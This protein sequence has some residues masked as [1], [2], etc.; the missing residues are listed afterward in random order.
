M[1]GKILLIL[2]IAIIII[3]TLT[4]ITYATSFIA[5]NLISPI[6]SVPFLWARLLIDVFVYIISLTIVFLAGA[7]IGKFIERRVPVGLDHLRASMIS[8]AIGIISG[9]IVIFLL[10]VHIFGLMVTST[11]FMAVLIFVMAFSFIPWLL[12]PMIINISYRCKHDPEL[13][14]IVNNIAKKA[15]LKPPKAMLAEMAVPNAFAYSSPIMGRYVA[16]TTGLLRIMSSKNELEA[17][18][19]HELGHHRH[20]DNAV[21]MLFGLIPTIIYFLGR[22]L[23]FQ[24]LMSRYIDGGE[25]RRTTGGSALT[26]VMV[27]LALIVISIIFQLAVL[28]LSRL[29]EYFA[30]AHGAKVTSPYSMINALRSLDRFYRSTGAKKLIANSKLKPLF[31]YALAEPFINLEELLAT[32]PPIYK[33]IQFLESLTGKE[34]KA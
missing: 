16:V 22:F 17:V 27:G 19:G 9:A 20:R 11:L 8:T 25:G 21:I 34:I 23:L 12:A 4:I 29:R 2:S 33:R 14:E 5:P 30:D 31:I 28:A 24:G 3:F 6:D 1:R 7:S 32:H 10:L 18:I 26:F 13:Q 15:G